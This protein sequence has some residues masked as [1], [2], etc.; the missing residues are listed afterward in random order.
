MSTLRLYDHHLAKVEE[1][2]HH[3][4]DAQG[5]EA[6]ALVHA[7]RLLIEQETLIQFPWDRQ[8]MI[9][10]CWKGNVNL[11]YKR[12]WFLIV[13]ADVSKLEAYRGMLSVS[14][15]TSQP[16]AQWEMLTFNIRGSDIWTTFTSTYLN[17]TSTKMYN[18]LKNL[19]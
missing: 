17:F 10:W 16:N 13:I 7:M 2:G 12:H 14:E 15:G 3:P 5:A 9:G 18:K 4:K 8:Q 6:E 1:E 11:P 19:D